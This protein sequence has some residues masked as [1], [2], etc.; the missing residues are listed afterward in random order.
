M[1]NLQAQ[2]PSSPPSVRSEERDEISVFI[3]ATHFQEGQMSISGESASVS[4]LSQG[5]V[6]LTSWWRCDQQRE[7]C[8]NAVAVE[9]PEVNLNPR[10][11]TESTETP[12]DYR[13]F[14]NIPLNL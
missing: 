10:K 3:P 12:V 8:L 9:I 13:H 1:F 4:G 11:Q 5:R 14:T 6:S 2:N 7:V